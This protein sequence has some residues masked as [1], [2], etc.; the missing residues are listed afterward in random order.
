M[1][2]ITMV[3]L[4]S[5]IDKTEYSILADGRTTLCL[6]TL[7]N[8]YTVTGTSSCID[9]SIFDKEKGEQAAL[10]HAHDKTFGYMAA[11]LVDRISDTPLQFIDEPCIAPETDDDDD[12]DIGWAVQQMRKGKKVARKG[13]NGSGMFAYLVPAATYKAHTKA[14]QSHFGDDVPYREYMALK[15]AQNDVAAWTP[16]IS[17][18]LATDWVLVH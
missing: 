15:T 14:A 3:D 1:A 2:K 12:N 18:V 16:S 17:D 11:V 8:G 4:V 6:L 9:I 13:W 7:C 5:A 10:R